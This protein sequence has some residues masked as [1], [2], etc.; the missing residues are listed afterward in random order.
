MVHKAKDPTT[1]EKMWDDFS[2][3]KQAGGGDVSDGQVRVAQPIR[4][5]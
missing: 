2:N 3:R 1:V 4:F 5:E